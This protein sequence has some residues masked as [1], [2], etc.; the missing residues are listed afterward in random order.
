MLTVC[1]SDLVATACAP[2]LPSGCEQPCSYLASIMQFFFGFMSTRLY[3]STELLSSLGVGN[4][5]VIR[6]VVD[7]IN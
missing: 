2:R 4:G 6:C 5:A 3:P 1:G 7:A